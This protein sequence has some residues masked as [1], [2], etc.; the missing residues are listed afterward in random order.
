MAQSGLQSA[1]LRSLD[2]DYVKLAR[3]IKPPPAQGW[4]FMSCSHCQELGQPA[5]LGSDWL[6]T[7]VQPVRS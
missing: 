5:D 3:D 7:L 6:F 1:S 4:K 2:N